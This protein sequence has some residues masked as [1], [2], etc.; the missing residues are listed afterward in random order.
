MIPLGLLLGLGLVST[1]RWGK[2]FP[3]GP[4]PQKGRLLNTPENFA[5]NVLPPQQ[6]TFIPV[7]SG[8]P[9]RTAV[10][11]D[12][13]SYEDFALPWDPAHVKVCVL[14]LRMGSP[15]PS[16]PW[17]FCAQAPLAFNSRC[18]RS[19]FSQCH[20]PKCGSLMWGSEL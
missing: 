8:C 15:Y 12:L 1:D 10:R 5:S 6:A 18:P 16:V 2:I 20:I 3:K 19:S 14:L 11:F 9:P 13:D 17:S 7:F 4:P